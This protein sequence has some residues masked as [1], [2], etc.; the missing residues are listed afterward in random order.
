MSD[1]LAGRKPASYVREV[2]E[3]AEA[4]YPRG[5]LA[6]AVLRQPRSAAHHRAGGLAGGARGVGR[7]V[8]ARRRAACSTTAWKWATPPNP[9]APALFERAPI[10]W[11][12]AERRPQVDAL[13][14]ALAALR[15]AHPAF[16]RGEVRWL[17]NG[18]E[19]RVL[20]YERTAP[21]NRVAG[22]RG[23]PVVAAAFR[24]SAM[25]GSG[26]LPGHHAG[27]PIRAGA[28]TPPDCSWTPPA[29][30]GFLAPW[31]FRVFR[32]ATP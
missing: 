26:R 8:H 4:K 28:A 30:S 11:E 19:Q 16:T 1:A 12:M 17:R 9:L 23:Q 18:D 21:A 29:S 13:L 2:W 24:A 22:R 3:R 14:P 7:D 27:M 31:E 20:S 5:A 25:Y 6:A 32:R 15:R 10:H